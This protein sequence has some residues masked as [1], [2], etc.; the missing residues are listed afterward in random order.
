M[1]T[2]YGFTKLC[3][4]SLR[5][6]AGAGH[7]EADSCCPIF[8]F[9]IVSCLLIWLII[10]LNF[11]GVSV[12]HWGYLAFGFFFSFCSIL[13]YVS[14]KR[15]DWSVWL[16]SSYDYDI[17]NFIQLLEIYMLKVIGLFWIYFFFKKK[18][19]KIK[20]LKMVRPKG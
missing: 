2:E 14:K 18:I 15:K 16:V 3:L 13:I 8:F 5:I 12:Y 6:E 1:V 4:S 17:E 20:V 19:I 10:L 9:L 11:L 7:G